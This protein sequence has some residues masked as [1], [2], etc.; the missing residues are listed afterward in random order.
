LNR[1][2][3]LSYEKVKLNQEYTTV[4]MWSSKSTLFPTGLFPEEICWLLSFF[5]FFIFLLLFIC[6]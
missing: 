1:E 4:T 6:A 5:F 2:L 3:F